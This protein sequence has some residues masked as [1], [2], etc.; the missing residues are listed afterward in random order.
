MNQEVLFAKTLEEV[1][2]LAIEQN[3]VI[4]K[5][6]VEEAFGRI[7]MKPEELTPIYEY[8]KQKK[9]GM[10]TPVDPVRSISRGE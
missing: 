5:E 4:S 9:I 10:G 3:R 6:Q 1:K 2:S 8:L 7:G